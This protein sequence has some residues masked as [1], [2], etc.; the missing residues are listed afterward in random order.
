MC[1]SHTLSL[2]LLYQHFLLVS[3]INFGIFIRSEFIESRSHTA[4]KPTPR[5]SKP[6]ST[7]AIETSSQLTEELVRQ[8]DTDAD[9]SSIDRSS[10]DYSET[11]KFWQSLE[12]SGSLD[13]Q[14]PPPVPKPRLS[15][16]IKLPRSS[17]ESSD[18]E[19]AIPPASVERIS[20]SFAEDNI[21]QTSSSKISSEAQV[22][23][24]ESSSLKTDTRPEIMRDD[25]SISADYRLENESFPKSDHLDSEPIDVKSREPDIS[26][27]SIS[28]DSAERSSASAYKVNKERE[29]DILDLDD[30]TQEPPRRGSSILHEQDEDE[31]NESDAAAA[32]FYIGESSGNIITK[33]ATEKRAEYAYDNAGYESTKDSTQSASVTETQKVVQFEDNAEP[34]VEFESKEDLSAKAQQTQSFLDAERNVESLSESLV[35]EKCETEPSEKLSYDQLKQQT[36]EFIES[37]KQIDSLEY[38]SS[39][40]PIQFESHVSIEEVGRESLD[41][42]NE[43]AAGEPIVNFPEEN[44]IKENRQSVFIEQ[45]D[46]ADS[47]PTAEPQIATMVHSPIEAQEFA[48]ETEY[49]A[50][51]DTNVIEQ[52]AIETVE[53][54]SVASIFKSQQSHYEKVKEFDIMSSKT[55]AVQHSPVDT[56]KSISERFI[57]NEVTDASILKSTEITDT[58]APESYSEEFN[59]VKSAPAT[60]SPKETA[61]GTAKPFEF[62]EKSTRQVTSAVVHDTSSFDPF[63]DDK[64]KRAPVVH[65]PVEVVKK[66]IVAELQPSPDRS[67]ETK[68]PYDESSSSNGGSA[69]KLDVIHRRTKTSKAPPTSRWSTTDPENYS[70][71]GDSLS[72]SRPC[73]SDVE[74]LYASCATSTAEYQTARDASYVPGSTTEYHTAASTFDHSGKTISSEESMKSFDSESSGHLGSVEI[75]EA[76]ETLVP[77]T[78]DAD[79]FTDTQTRELELEFDENEQRLSSLE[80]FSEQILDENLE[81]NRLDRHRTS[82]LKRSQEMIFHPEISNLQSMESLTLEERTD[83]SER[84]ISDEELK[85]DE[86]KF[87]TSATDS[88]LSMSLSS[89]SN[90]DVTMVENVQDDLASS[91]GSGSL[92]G[93]YET[94]TLLKDDMT[95]TS[96]DEKYHTQPIESMVMTTTVIKDDDDFTS[97]NT[98]IT[99]DLKS[100]SNE[101]PDTTETVGRRGKG[102]KRNDSTSFIGNLDM[103]KLS[104]ESTD[105]SSLDDEMIIHDVPEDDKR[106]SGSDSDYDRY[107][108]EYSRSFKQPGSKRKKKT[109]AAKVIQKPEIDEKLE[110]KK[111][112]PC[113]ETIVEDVVA[114]DIVEVEK[115]RAASQNMLDYSNIPDIMITDDPT[116][117]VSDSDEDV[118]Q[119]KEPEIVE[120]PKVVERSAPRSTETAEEIITKISDEQ[121]EQLIEQ[122]YKTKEFEEMK[123]DSPTSDSFELVEQPDISDEFVIIEEVAKEADELM[124]EGKSVS[125][126]QTKYV[127]KHDDE[128]EKILVKSA[129]AATNEGSTILQGRHDLAFEFEDSPSSGA[130]TESSEEGGLESS[131]KWVE[132][133]LAEQAQ[134][135]RYPYDVDRGMLEDIKEEDTDFEVGSSRI[136]SFK[137]SYSSTDFDAAAARRYRTKEQDDV[138]INSL[139]EFERLEQAISLEN[140]KFYGSS[141]DSSSNGSFPKRGLRSVQADEIS[142]SSLKDFEGLENACLEAHLLEIK[143]KEEHALLLSR[144]DESNK[145][146]K[147]DDG[148]KVVETTTVVTTKAEPVKGSADGTQ[149][150]SQTIVTKVVAESRS[151]PRSTEP[152]DDFSSSNLMEVSTDSLEFGA[153]QAKHSVHSKNTSQYGSSDSLEISKS[154]GDVMTSSIDSIEVSKENARSSK[155]DNDSIEQIGRGEKRDSIDSIDA[156]YAAM[157]QSMH[158]QR[159]SFDANTFVD[160]TSSVTTSGSQLTE[161]KTITVSATSSSGYGGGISKDISSDSLNIHQSEP[162]LLITSTESLDQTSSTFATYQNQSDSQMTM[163]GSMTSCD[164]N[165]LVDSSENTYSANRDPTTSLLSGIDFDEKF[166]TRMTSTTVTTTTV[167]KATSGSS[168]VDKK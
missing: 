147:S 40:D 44:I 29:C 121:Y 21:S 140:R 6:I 55:G 168:D 128:V 23:H 10:G 84:K 133:Q 41:D 155:S 69:N 8:K 36:E 130:A 125:I 115:I 58:T 132:M 90:A 105:S 100:E 85:G 5:Y 152:D 47:D 96:F 33:T 119:K 109:M 88:I 43:S 123:S 37:E 64:P 73:S 53:R 81:D 101:S 59:T 127:K 71:A 86:S 104:M 79:F 98:Q 1:L 153:K 160:F 67:E 56:V 136:S 78:A 166:G 35:E 25:D 12:A 144:S 62:E 70:S 122:Q 72:N 120:K 15:M 94:K 74:N 39:S 141:H 42:R 124:T 57:D 19:K 87:G 129:P 27:E 113:I 165:T 32:S 14:A 158:F 9:N 145:S 99:T 126:K 34:L 143:A 13:E 16:E 138:S 82:S 102:H 103:A 60:C 151:K 52:G 20:V 162:E 3:I 106:E 150:A 137:D 167:H 51:I 45:L 148:A 77:S 149:F 83:S 107:E 26:I 76:S 164:S 61:K 163:S 18:V 156:Q 159:D 146:G 54:E 49:A 50:P 30:E 111:S 112:V 22:E 68:Q 46:S 97:V 135:L 65:S 108:T 75:S 66:E 131:K 92:V 91:L 154:G 95:G 93:S 116:K 24:S 17:D 48:V 38:D 157:T 89:T 11:K 7:D 110:R 142:L 118:E 80:T 28:L 117:Y 139:Q 114:E 161:S 4:P 2:S 31:E 134:A 63:F